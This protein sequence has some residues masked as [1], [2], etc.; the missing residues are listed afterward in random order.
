MK[1]LLLLMVAI[2]VVVLSILPIKAQYG[3]SENLSLS[4]TIVEAVNNS[5][6]YCEKINNIF[7]NNKIKIE[8][9][10]ESAR[11]LKEHMDSVNAAI[12]K[13]NNRRNEIKR[14]IVSS[15][16]TVD[17][18][19]DLS[20]NSVYVTEDD[21]NIIISHFDPNGT[22]PFYGQGRIFIEASKQSGL[23]PIYIFAHASWE[24][25]YGRS[26]LANDRG[27]YFGI[28]AVDINPDAA[29]NMGS[30]VEAG[31]INGAVWISNNYYKNG[32]T[33][34]HSMIYGAKKYAS[35]EDKWING[36]SS[37]MRESYSVLKNYRGLEV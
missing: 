12:A 19:S 3:N 4:T 16:Y 7:T 23:D 17:R 32:Q 24:S 6:E 36:I 14:K 27:N 35:A 26:Y 2:S 15:R 34:L 8:D 20:N 5:N 33:T 9:K 29:S 28:N 18:N 13:E 30:N 21:M 22:S 11:I 31:I 37:I 1:K 10:E 25:D